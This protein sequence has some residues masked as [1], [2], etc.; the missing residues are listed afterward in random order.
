MGKNE[1]TIMPDDLPEVFRGKVRRHTM[2]EIKMLLIDAIQLPREDDRHCVAKFLI[3]MAEDRLLHS[4][5]W[6]AERKEAEEILSNL[7]MWAGKYGRPKKSPGD[8]E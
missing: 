7:K 2:R 4:S 1:E 8:G 5:D 6:M 3:D